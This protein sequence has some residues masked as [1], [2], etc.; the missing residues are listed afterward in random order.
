MM[1]LA[2]FAGTDQ[3]LREW[4]AAFGWPTE[5]LI[6]LLLA[7]AAGG[8]IGLER[9]ARNRGAGF[10]THI[11]VCLGSALVMIISTRLAYYEWPLQPYGENRVNID[12]GRIAYGVMTGVG[13]LGAGTIIERRG[14]AKG[15]TTAAAIWCVAAIGMAMGFGLYYLGIATTLLVLASLWLLDYA[16]SFIPSSRGRIVTVRVPHGPRAAQDLVGRFQSAGLRVD[17]MEFARVPG[18]D[19]KTDVTLNVLAQ[20]SVDYV[21]VETR[22][23][24][25]QGLDVRESREQ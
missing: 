4:V 24:E 7:V 11:L 12:P 5:G 15:L 25:E 13:F 2:L 8:L 10:R 20:R 19:S 14:R 16:E 23:A 6:R 17:R 1:S 3:S 9:E 21:S 22:L 18:D